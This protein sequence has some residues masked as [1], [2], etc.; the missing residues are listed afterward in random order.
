VVRLRISALAD[1]AVFHAHLVLWSAFSNRPRLVARK[2]RPSQPLK[3]PNTGP[4][5]LLI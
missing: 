4:I 2:R 5:G 1:E 3:Q